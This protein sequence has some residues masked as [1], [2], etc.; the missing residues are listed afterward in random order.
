MIWMFYWT[1][2]LYDDALELVDITDDSVITR[3]EFG[4]E[5]EGKGEDQEEGEEGE[6][7]LEGGGTSLYHIPGELF[8]LLFYSATVYTTYLHRRAIYRS[9]RGRGHTAGPS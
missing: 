5:S 4:L 9:S 7:V 3:M 8:N 2:D 1:R 6:R